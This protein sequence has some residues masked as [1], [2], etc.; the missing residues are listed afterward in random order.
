LG[1]YIAAITLW[2]V[3]DIP[4]KFLLFGWLGTD[5]TI[6]FI[7]RTLASGLVGW[8]ILSM[9]VGEFCTVTRRDVL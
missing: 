4:V 8:G 6:G 7:A 9:V 3:A 1:S 2:I 5:S